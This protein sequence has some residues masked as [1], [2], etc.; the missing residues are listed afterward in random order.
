[1]LAHLAVMRLLPKEI[2][3]YIRTWPHLVNQ[4]QAVINKLGFQHRIRVG[5][6]I[7]WHDYIQEIAS[8]K[9]FVSLDG[10]YTWGRFD[11]DAA[12]VGGRCIGTHSEMK[13]MFFPE[14][15]IGP[16][17]VYEAADMVKQELENTEVYQVSHEQEML[18]SHELVK[19]HI[20]EE[21]EKL[22]YY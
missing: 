15:I 16:A 7:Y 10:R 4:L 2:I 22:F 12:A 5:P 20:S 9:A 21:V 6:F 1:M 14:L 17:D 18:F 3:G 8:Y 11:L 19:K 13:R